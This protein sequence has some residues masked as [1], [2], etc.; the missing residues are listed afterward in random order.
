MLQISTKFVTE[1]GK[2]AACRLNVYKVFT[3]GTGDE[4]V[5]FSINV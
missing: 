5:M 4:M 1:S 3:Y 2:V